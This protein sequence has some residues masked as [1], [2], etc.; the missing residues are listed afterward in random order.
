[1]FWVTCLLCAIGRTCMAKGRR[2]GRDWGTSI[3]LG[4]PSLEAHNMI[5]SLLRDWPHYGRDWS[6]IGWLLEGVR[7][8]QYRI[9]PKIPAGDNNFKHILAGQVPSLLLFLFLFFSLSLHPTKVKNGCEAEHM[10]PLMFLFLLWFGPIAI[11]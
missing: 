3:C 9:T 8:T 1:M 7:K 6:A 11:R 5:P 2:L 10:T 4:H